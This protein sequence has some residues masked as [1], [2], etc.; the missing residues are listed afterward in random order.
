MLSSIAKTIQ[1]ITL[2]ASRRMLRRTGKVLFGGVPAAA[3]GYA[4]Y[5]AFCPPKV[6]E[7]SETCCVVTGASMGI[8]K[9]IAKGLADE[10]VTK[11]VIAARSKDALEKVKA[12]IVATHPSASV[13]IVPTDVS[14]PASREN[15][16]KQSL[17]HAGAS[18]ITLVNNAGVEAM[19][20]IERPPTKASVANVDRQIDI[21]LRAPI[22]LTELFMP[23]LCKSGG[24]VVNIS[25]LAGKMSAPYMSACASHHLPPPRASPASPPEAGVWSLNSHGAGR[26]RDI[27]H[28]GRHTHKHTP[29]RRK[30]SVVMGSAASLHRQRV[31]VWPCGL[32]EVRALRVQAQEAA[33]LMLG[34]LPGLCDE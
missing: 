4:T 10:G 14:S 23:E 21:N 26:G 11:L 22:H 2:L 20:H 28:R 34:H 7:I 33:R 30:R 24:H 32:H 31:Q 29:C 6:A 13:L 9:H 1:G 8:G 16:L 5:S 19:M 12:D 15:L 3:L 18:K 17:S 27:T 25:S